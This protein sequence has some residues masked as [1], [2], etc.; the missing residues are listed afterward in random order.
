[1]P[2]SSPTFVF[3]RPGPGGLEVF[4]SS[5]DPAEVAKRWQEA[6]VS[7]RPLRVMRDGQIGHPNIE[8]ARRVYDARDA[9]AREGQEQ[10]DRKR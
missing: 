6:D 2:D 7:F 1:M 3:L 8:E 4:W 5:S 9:L 10:K